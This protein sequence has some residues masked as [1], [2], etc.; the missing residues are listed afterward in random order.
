MYLNKTELNISGNDLEINK[1]QVI[2]SNGFMV[3]GQFSPDSS[4]TYD[5][6]LSYVGKLV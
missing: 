4:D 6:N 5:L 1:G 2:E 3:L